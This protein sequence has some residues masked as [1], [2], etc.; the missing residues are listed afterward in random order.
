MNACLVL[1][2]TYPL[3]A[4]VSWYV[5]SPYTKLSNTTLPSL[6]VTALD[7]TLPSL[8]NTVTSVPGKNFLASFASTFVISIFPII[9]SSDTV[10]LTT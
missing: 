3:G 4:L 10:L 7:T 6:S 1:S 9:L 8:S 2:I 5:Y